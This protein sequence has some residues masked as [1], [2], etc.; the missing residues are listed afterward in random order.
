MT[1]VMLFLL[2]SIFSSIGIQ[3]SLAQNDCSGQPP[4]FNYQDNKPS[5]EEPDFSG[6]FKVYNYKDNSVWTVNQMINPEIYHNL[7]NNP[8]SCEPVCIMCYKD[9]TEEEISMNKIH[10]QKVLE[11]V[12]GTW[13]MVTPI[14]IQLRA[15]SGF[16][17][18]LFANLVLQVVHHL[19]YVETLNG[20]YPLVTIAEREGDCDNLSTLA[21]AI[22]K[23]GGLD[24]VVVIIPVGVGDCFGP[25]RHAMVGVHLSEPPNSD[26]YASPNYDPDRNYPNYVTDDN[27]E[28]YYLA[29]AT[30]Y[31]KS[32]L[33]I[34]SASQYDTYAANDG[35]LVGENTAS[36]SDPEI[37]VIA[38]SP[39][40]LFNDMQRPVPG[41][42]SPNDFSCHRQLKDTVNNIRVD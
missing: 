26:A 7:K 31:N 14:A 8:V 24:S 28:K 12:L 39:I 30:W 16:D 9:A 23:A 37:M 18:E 25:S 29:E 32:P 42:C 21:A 17:D 35:S 27:S 10:S 1:P 41:S 20:K 4:V 36:I 40:K 22:M 38:E 11:K 34:T 13:P 19:K 33:P 3:P 2:C 6:Q 5:L 15:I